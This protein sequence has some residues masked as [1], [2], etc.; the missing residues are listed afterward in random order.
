MVDSAEYQTYLPERKPSPEQYR[1][2]DRIEIVHLNITSDQP[3]NTREELIR[4]RIKLLRESGIEIQEVEIDT[5][6]GDLKNKNIVIGGALD[7][8]C[9]PKRRRFIIEHGGKAII[10]TSL[11][12]D[13]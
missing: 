10:D 3:G 6:Q 2:Y 1:K 4:K 9:G 12:T 7:D 11:S 13:Y 5:D 8:V